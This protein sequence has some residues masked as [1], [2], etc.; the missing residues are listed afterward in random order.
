LLDGLRILA[1]EVGA[2]PDEGNPDI[3]AARD[4]RY[5]ELTEALKQWKA[6]C[7]QAKV[8][9]GELD[10]WNRADELLTED[11]KLRA[12]IAATRAQTPAG[13]MAKLALVA[14][15]CEGLE[16]E[17]KGSSEDLLFS[18]AHDFNSLKPALATV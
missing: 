7:E 15:C 2:T 4:A 16:P 18:V 17:D 1:R 10:A 8:R 11:Q 5:R 3:R 9:S 14:P 13:M 12:R 6:G